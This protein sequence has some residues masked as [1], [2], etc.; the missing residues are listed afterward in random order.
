MDSISKQLVSGTANSEVVGQVLLTAG[1][2]SWICPPNV[3][4][5]SVVCIG[6]GSNYVSHGGSLRYKNNI[7]VIP[8]NS[9]PY[10]IPTPGDSLAGNRQT[11][12]I[13]NITVSANTGYGNYTGGLTQY[14]DGG[15]NGGVGSS[16]YGVGG[17]GAGG[18]TGNGGGPGAPGNG[19]GG[20][21]GGNSSSGPG[22]GGIGGYNG[23]GGGGVSP[24]GAGAS[25]TAGINK[26][27][28]T[29]PATGGQGGSSGGSGS[30]SGNGGG[31]SYGGGAGYY[32]AF[33]DNDG[34]PQKPMYGG[35]GCIRIIWPGNQ[36]QFPS[37]R[38][39]N[40]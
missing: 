27:Y 9:Y 40:E 25:G 36:R 1:S 13:S 35:P 38:T 29:G 23:G 31:G 22:P 20:G 21:G 4:S 10:S 32:N 17:A 34:Y 11:W 3:F 12:F 8:G 14:G 33:N 26:S 6:A 30:S 15:G 18:Y 39:A 5:V 16:S 7:P 37:T 2:G 28:Y 19:G 24:F